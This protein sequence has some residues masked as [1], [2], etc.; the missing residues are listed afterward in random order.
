V[1]VQYQRHISKTPAVAEK[2]P[3]GAYV[4]G[5]LQGEAWKRGKEKQASHA[6]LVRDFSNCHHHHQDHH[7]GISVP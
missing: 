7:G 2:V 1:Y 4:L 6:I 5:W 3:P